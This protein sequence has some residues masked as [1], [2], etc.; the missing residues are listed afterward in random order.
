MALPLIILSIVRFVFVVFVVP[1]QLAPFTSEFH[2]FLFAFGGLDLSLGLSRRS[3][4]SSS[5]WNGEMDG[6]V[7]VDCI[8]FWSAEVRMG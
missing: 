3:R 5:S 6:A 7:D 2:L 4:S 1:W 8:I